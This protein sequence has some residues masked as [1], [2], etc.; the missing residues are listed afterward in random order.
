MTLRTSI[1]GWVT[2]LLLSGAPGLLMQAQDSEDDFKTDS[3]PGKRTFNSVCAACHGLDGRGSDK[4]PGIVGNARVRRLSNAELS[5]IVSQGKPGTGMPAFRSLSV[6]E[7]RSIVNYVRA[8]QGSFE[9]RIPPGD[10]A[11]GKKVFVGKGECSSCHAV[12]GEGGFLGPDLTAYGS[13]R[14]AKTIRSAIAN[15]LRVMAYGYRSA[16]VT[17]SDGTRVGGVV[18]NEDNFSIQ[19]QTADGA[20]HFFPKSDLQR[21]EYLEQPLMP[22][23]YG[24]RLTSQEIDDLVSY[25]MAVG[26]PNKVARGSADKHGKEAP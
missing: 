24:E 4:A 23:N 10:P 18:R 11:Q 5:Q 25:L 8:L 3:L 15:P 19:L 7:V 12:E 17:S 22:T 9:A 26:S 1:L 14:P 13:N 21:L 16:A 6:A 20:F 2:M